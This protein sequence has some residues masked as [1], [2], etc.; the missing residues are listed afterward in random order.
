LIYATGG[1]A[2]GELEAQPAGFSAESHTTLGWT[3]G[4]G[5]EAGFA[6]HWSGRIE[7]LFVDLASSNFAVTGASNGYSAS[8]FRAG[9]NYHF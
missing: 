9:V 1:L 8:V 6:S 3:A 4:G 7:Y 5:I 2:F